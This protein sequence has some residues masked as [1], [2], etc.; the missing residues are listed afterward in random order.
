M[1]APDPD[2]APSMTTT[3]RRATGGALIASSLLLL[4][5]SAATAAPGRL[6]I[7]DDQI[8]V[9]PASTWQERLNLIGQ[10][11]AKLSRID[12][13]WSDVAPTRPANPRNHADPAYQWTKYDAFF[14]GLRARGIT[15]IA[16]IWSTPV[17]ATKSKAPIPAGQHHNARSPENAKDFGDFVQ[18]FISRYRPGSKD[19][20]GTAL[21]SVRIVEAWNEPNLNYGLIPESG[22]R[23]DIYAALAKAAHAE[24]RTARPKV[25]LLIGAGGPASSTGD[26][27]VGA[28]LWVR[29]LAKRKVTGDGYSQHMYPKAGPANPAKVI[30][31]WGGL[32]I[33]A[34]EIDAI[35]TGMPIWITEAGYTTA[36]TPY[37]KD[38]HVSEKTQATY[39]RQMMQ[40]PMVRSGRVKAVIWFNM[41]DNVNWPSGLIR[42]D[43][44]KKPSW[45][46]FRSL[47]R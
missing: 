32:P 20:S 29:Q 30:P 42:A 45:A 38:A 43:G 35:R 4:G 12:V 18:A 36:A 10:S 11:R 1:C 2:P 7:Q 15:P 21:P 19:A 14:R 31:G 27:Q 40:V 8:T 34:K 25:T 17:W 37:R 3:L 23:A 28:K 22:S 41:Q 5:A 13:F 46:V 39:L 47:A 26:S 33:L 44:S 6:G 9:A 16:A 24:T